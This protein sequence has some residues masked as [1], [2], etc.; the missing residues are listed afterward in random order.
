MFKSNKFIIP[1]LFAFSLLLRLWNLDY[2]FSNDELSTVLRAHYHGIHE[3]IT[4]GVLID[5]HPAG[6]QVFITYWVKI[7]GDSEFAVRFPFAIFG[8]IAVVFSFLYTRKKLSLTPALL[9]ALS[10]SILEFSLMHSQLVR[11]YSSGLML[12]MVSLWFWDKIVFEKELSTKQLIINSFLLAIVFAASAYN[13]YF[14]ALTSVILA[15]SGLFFIPFKRLWAYISLGILSAV[16]FIPHIDITLHH[17]SKGSIGSWLGAPSNDFLFKHIQHIFNDSI[18]LLFIT[19]ALIAIYAFLNRNTTKSKLLKFRILML[20]LFLSPMAIAYAYSVMIGPVLQDRILLFNMPFLLMF[21]FSFINEAKDKKLYILP[22]MIIVFMFIHTV[23]IDKYYSTS[24]FINF[25]KI[26]ELSAQTKLEKQNVL[27]LQNSN[28]RHYLQYYLIDTNLKFS[29]Y[30]LTSEDN[31]QSLKTILDTTN[32]DYCEFVNLRPIN[33]IS[34]LMINSSYLNIENTVIDKGENGYYLFSK[35]TN[36]VFNTNSSN[37]LDKAI[38]TPDIL[39]L[40]EYEFYNCIKYK[41][42][43]TSS[44]YIHFNIE[45]INDKSPNEALIVITSSENNKENKWTGIPFS[46]FSKSKTKS[47]IYGSWK[48]SIN[49]NEELSIYIWN[50]KKQSIVLVNSSISIKTD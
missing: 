35:N 29:T 39:N 9:T 19:I 36:R 37:T 43:K 47:Y 38:I 3:I 7:F 40:K 27:R 11:P 12:S 33:Q 16:L 48:Y 49:K 15:I 34:L 45:F 41:P 42:T 6:V 28:S 50:P 13:H 5:F 1:A 4:K 21:V 10:L 17:L 2:S 24:H 31:L 30:Q 22:L 20:F 25:K 8:S 23:F 44:V 32:A 26:A 14:S 46:Y 18:P